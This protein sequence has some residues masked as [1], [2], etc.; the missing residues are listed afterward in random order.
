MLYFF[1]TVVCLIAVTAGLVAHRR[2]SAGK[3]AQ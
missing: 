1:L 3:A 2:H